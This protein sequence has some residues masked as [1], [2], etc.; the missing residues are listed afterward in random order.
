MA[1]TT[2]AAA[3]GAAGGQLNP[4]APAAALSDAVVDAATNL[5]QQLQVSGRVVGTGL[6]AGHAGRGGGVCGQHEWASPPVGS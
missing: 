3:G 4:S 6:Q 2:A 1:P 5:E